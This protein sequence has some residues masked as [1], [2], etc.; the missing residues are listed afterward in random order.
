[1]L[2]SS[3]LTL[4]TLSTR[5]GAARIRELCKMMITFKGSRGYDKQTTRQK[6]I[7]VVF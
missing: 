7:Q 3:Q 6:E 1:M 5:T 2:L 4:L